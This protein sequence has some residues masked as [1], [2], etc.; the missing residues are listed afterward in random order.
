MT[1]KARHC[2]AATA[3]EAVSVG[4]AQRLT[5]LPLATAGVAQWA[6]ILSYLQ[7]QKSR[8]S[9]RYL[10]QEQKMDSNRKEGRC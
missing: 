5:G 8:E 10:H 3:G 6:G 1:D 9:Y 4:S 7:Q 2:C